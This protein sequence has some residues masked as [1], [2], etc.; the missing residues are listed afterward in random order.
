M[1]GKR[2]FAAFAKQGLVSPK[3]AIEASLSASDNVGIAGL[4]LS[5]NL[6]VGGSFSSGCQLDQCVFEFCSAQ[7]EVLLGKSR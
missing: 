6:Q 1:G 2:N 3:A 4:L 7:V 5:T